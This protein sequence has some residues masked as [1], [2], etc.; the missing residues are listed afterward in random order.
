MG[1]SMNIQREMQSFKVRIDAEIDAYMRQSIR[2]TRKHDVFVADALEYVRT[3]IL[4]GGKRVRAAMM[5]Y[6]YLAG[7]GKEYQ[8]ALEVCVSIEL[9][10]AFLLIHDDIM[11]RDGKRHGVDTVHRRYEKLAKRSRY[12]GD[13]AHFGESI[14]ITIGDIVAA[15]GSRR[16]FTSDFPAERI[17]LALNKL[18]FIISY[19]G[20]GQISDIRMG[21]SGRASEED[22]LAMYKHKTAKYSLE[23]PLHLGAILAGA[24][25]VFLEKLSQYAIPLGI[26]Y[27]IQDDLLGIFG[28]E[29]GVGKPIG[30]DIEEGK[31]TLLVVSALASGDARQKKILRSLLGRAG[32][33]KQELDLV[34][35]TF[36]DTGAVEY[37][38]EKALRYVEEG[39]RALEE[40]PSQSKKAAE[41]LYGMAEYVAS[42]SI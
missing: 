38:K 20:I 33:T 39:K 24:D 11:D 12:F 16:I 14:G 30:S 22:V 19:T 5:Y 8:K 42:R 32:I 28:K 3:C 31:M 41:F 29:S 6:G 17:V 35:D 4:S 40:I 10:H 15:M 9:I 1:F 21:V 37:A 25:E 2:E 26:A 13:P 34:R 18:Q 36:R 27:Q 23:G 7:G